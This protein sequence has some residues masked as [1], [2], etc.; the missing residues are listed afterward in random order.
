MD[1]K[2]CK[3]S[4]GCKRTLLPGLMIFSILIAA[5]FHLH[6]IHPVAYKGPIIRKGVKSKHIDIS[7]FERN[8]NNNNSSKLKCECDEVHYPALFIYRRS[9]KTGSSSM[10]EALLREL[11]PLGYHTVYDSDTVTRATVRG[12]FTKAMPQKL[13]V[14]EHNDITKSFHPRR[15][16]IIADTVRDGYKQMTSFCRFAFG[17]KKCDSKE[18]KSC[19]ASEEL[20]KHLKYRW[21]WKDEEDEDTYIDLPLSVDYPALT[22]TIFR[23]V[24]P[25]TTLQIEHFHILNTTCE[26]IPNIRKEYE[27]QLGDLDNQILKLRIRMLILAGY[28][29]RFLNHLG[30]ISIDEMMIAAERREQMKYKLKSSEIKKELYGPRYYE[31]RNGYL[32]WNKTEK[33]ELEIVKSDEYCFGEGC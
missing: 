12:E 17:V 27:K 18:M 25:T 21:A 15:N 3:F 31:C 22:N 11:V 24:F 7:N 20:R 6:F 28:P 10:V 33:G 2:S 30:N 8:F 32:R 16:A 23:R 29:Y 19:F 1:S 26:E 5:N 9:R 14:A 13:F 4:T